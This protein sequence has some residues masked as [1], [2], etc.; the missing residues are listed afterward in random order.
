MLMLH[1]FRMQYVYVPVVVVLVEEVTVLLLLLP[2]TAVT[3]TV[4][5]LPALREVMV[6]VVVVP[7]T[8]T[9]DDMYSSE[10]HNS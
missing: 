8:V 5:L 2:N 3:L 1:A 6:W 10:S 7:S 9:D 4:Q